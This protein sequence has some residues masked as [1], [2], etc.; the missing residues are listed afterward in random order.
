MT[1]EPCPSAPVHSHQIQVRLK[2][3]QVNELIRDYKPG[4][5]I[6]E[7]VRSLRDQPSNRHEARERAALAKRHPGISDPEEVIKRYKAGQSIQT[8]A[9]ALGSCNRTVH[10]VLCD[11]NVAMRKPYGHMLEHVPMSP[12]ADE[13]SITR[14]HSPKMPTS[15]PSPI[16]PLIPGRSFRYD[17][18]SLTVNPWSS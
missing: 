4:I 10:K 13:L 11:A 17:T 15:S 9:D 18:D 6:N 5:K 12:D 14:A 7:I 1:P 16:F 8:I 2:P 3:E